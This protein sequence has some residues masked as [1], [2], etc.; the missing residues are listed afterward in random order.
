MTGDETWILRISGS[1]LFAAEKLSQRLSVFSAAA[2]DKPN[3][4][5]QRSLEFGLFVVDFAMQPDGQRLFVIGQ[6]IKDDSTS[7]RLFA[8]DPRTGQQLH[9]VTL[10]YADAI[11]VNATRVFCGG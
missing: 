9:T 10:E 11:V 7:T 1:E 2:A 3:R 8:F 4:A 5:P 6:T